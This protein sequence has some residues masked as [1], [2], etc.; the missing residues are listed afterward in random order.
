MLNKRG[1]HCREQEGAGEYESER[2]MYSL[3][4]DDFPLHNES[5]AEDLPEVDILFQNLY[6][7]PTV[8]LSRT[9]SKACRLQ[10]IVG[11]FFILF[12]HRQEPVNCVQR[13]LVG[14]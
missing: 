8:M 5:P 12:H 7:A 9:R 1:Y 11:R 10:H 3:Q 2:P 14:W 4:S 6:A 13:R